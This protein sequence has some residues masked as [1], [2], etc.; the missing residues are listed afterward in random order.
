[1]RDLPLVAVVG[2]VTALAVVYGGDDLCACGPLAAPSTGAGDQTPATEVLTLA[3]S[4]PAICETGP[5]QG[6]S[7]SALRQ[8]EDGNWTKRVEVFIG[9]FEVGEVQVSWEVSGGTAPYTLTIDGEARDARQSYEG[10][11]GTAS[12]SCAHSFDETFIDSQERGYR[13][14][15]TIDSGSKLVRATVTDA[16][17]STFTASVQVYVIMS[18]EHGGTIMQGGNTYRVFGRLM[19]IPEGIDMRIDGIVKGDGGQSG[20]GLTVE[21]QPRAGLVLSMSSFAELK[22]DVPASD[23]PGADGRPINLGDKFDELV[24]SAGRLPV[25]PKDSP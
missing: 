2:I 25:V 10:E 3:L 21:D 18:V 23:A 11:R 22:R 19:T 15:P 8:D 17:G 5:A 24:A 9:W 20:F 4:A 12:V 1:M 6:Y 16:N 7:G 14:E 13:E